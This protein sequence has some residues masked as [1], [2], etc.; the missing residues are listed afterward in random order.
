MMLCLLKHIF[1]QCV[2]FLPQHLPVISMFFIRNEWE[3]EQDH[4]E[5]Q[6]LQN[7]S[8]SLKIQPQ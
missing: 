6:F 8:L 3:C 2:A 1:M 5:N 7:R 4:P